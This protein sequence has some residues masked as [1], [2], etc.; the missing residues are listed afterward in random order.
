M[1]QQRT[2]GHAP[3]AQGSSWDVS[4]QQWTT[5]AISSRVIRLSKQKRHNMI[6]VEIPAVVTISK[7]QYSSKWQAPQRWYLQFIHNNLH[8]PIRITCINLFHTED[9]RVHIVTRA[10]TIIVFKLQLAHSA[11]TRNIHHKRYIPRPLSSSKHM[12]HRK[13]IP[14]VNTAGR[15]WP[16]C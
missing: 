5:I 15:I 12:I 4:P 10:C 6:M 8:I 2:L 11:N 3:L 13:I 1:L 14:I 16:T 7:F 9:L